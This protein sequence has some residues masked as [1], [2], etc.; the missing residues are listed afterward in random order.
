MIFEVTNSQ[1][2]KKAVK[3]A[4][5]KV[6]RDKT[7]TI[8]K[9]ELTL[10]LCH[11]VFNLSKKVPG[12]A[13]PPLRSDVDEFYDTY[14][15]DRSGD[16]D[17]EEFE[18]F[19]KEWVRR[20]GKNFMWILAGGIVVNFIVIP[21]VAAE[22]HNEVKLFRKVPVGLIAGAMALLVKRAATAFQRV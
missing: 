10:A 21:A 15:R 22:I 2:F 17:L 9:D 1:A 6:D 11:F 14:D 8:N 19:V 18:D 7:G 13:S 4:F 12:V 3:V 20:N 5:K 16:L